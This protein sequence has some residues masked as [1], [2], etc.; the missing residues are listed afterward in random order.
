MAT[1]FFFLFV[2]S[3]LISCNKYLEK[4]PTQNLAVPSSLSELQAILDN[5]RGNNSAP[6]YTELVADN[7][8]LT[9]PIWN[10]LNVDLRRNYVWDKDAAVTIETTIW[11][12]PY[13]A[14][15]NANF[16]LDNLPK[17]KG[18]END[19]ETYNNIKGTALFYR[20]FMFHQLAQLFCKP[21]SSSA[22]SDFGIVL[23]TT[24]D[25]ESSLKRSTVQETYDQ[26]LNDLKSAAE[27]LPST[28]LFAT[29][30]NKA[31]AYAELARVY[32]SMRDYVNADLYAHNALKLY[33]TLLDYN[34]LTPGSNPIL[35]IN[36]VNNPE[37]LF[38]SWTTNGV[39]SSSNLAIVDT[40]LYKSYNAN[41]LRK[42]VFFGSSGSNIYWKGS[43]YAFQGLAYSIFDGLA[44]DEIY[45]IRAECR[46]RNGNFTGAMDD[47]NL[48]LRKRWKSSTFTDLTAADAADALNK[49]LTE[50]RKELAFR[51]LRWSD[52]RRFNLD[53][54]SITLTRVINGTSYT[55][56]PNDLRWVL[57]IPEIEISR[58]AISQNPR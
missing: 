37:I 52:L 38:M 42:S 31:A 20:A 11:S 28:Q 58:S 33:N 1:S 5:Q 41:D 22:T 55:L 9:T 2:I 25:P 14:V 7:Y 4:K 54:A 21:Y 40:N 10:Q 12:N 23:K 17:I 53:G 26:I 3:S 6:D 32:L 36:P 18:V 49:V 57:L 56:P 45:L 50:R 24:S 39:F 30:P 15:Y 46:A 19:A 44:T 16:V 29:R 43:Y 27:I 48:L 51:G 35:P 34:S 8:Y 13:V 47:L